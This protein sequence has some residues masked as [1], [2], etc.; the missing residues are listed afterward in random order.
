MQA[1]FILLAGFSDSA[2]AFGVALL[3]L[4]IRVELRK[5]KFNICIVHFFSSLSLH[6]EGYAL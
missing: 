1:I 6:A 3:G 4:N 2:L 5:Q